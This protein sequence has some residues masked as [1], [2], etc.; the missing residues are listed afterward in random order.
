MRQ[1][2]RKVP[3]ELSKAE[4]QRLLDLPSISA[5]RKYLLFLFGCEMTH[6][7]Q[8]KKKAER[9]VLRL[10]QLE[11]QKEMEKDMHIV[12]G[13]GRNSMFLKVYDTTINHW[14]NN[15]LTRAM[16]FSQK[17]VIDC[18]YDEHM[19][20][21]EAD[22]CAKQLCFTFAMNRL[23]DQPLDLH[24][25][26]LDT[27]NTK[28]GKKLLNHIPTMYNPEFPMN[29]HKESYM[30]LFDKE[31]LVYLTPHCRNDLVEYN[32]DDIYIVGAMVDKAN[33]EPISL[34]KAKKLGLRMA[35]LPLNRYLH[36]GI[37]GKS[38]AINQMVEI[39][40]EMRTTNDWNQAL[41]FVPRRKLFNDKL[42]QS[43]RPQF[44]QNQ[45]RGR[46]TSSKDYIDDSRNDRPYQRRNNNYQQFEDEE[47]RYEQPARPTKQRQQFEKYFDLDSWGSGQVKKKTN[48][49]R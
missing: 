12:Y 45:Q 26:N 31:K 36:W 34:A 17:L 4:M 29:V 38:L 27:E 28:S 18:S 41:R 16:Q 10:Q 33:N 37:G 9:Q 2:G 44:G 3:T 39:M 20:F 22:N 5:R 49:N 42:E 8:K 40:L 6:I 19:T 23:H 48:D 25:C 14:H 43:Q 1:E 47:E 30:D 13:L 15:R 32:H 21:R 7:N 35:K 24:Y 46:I 11:E